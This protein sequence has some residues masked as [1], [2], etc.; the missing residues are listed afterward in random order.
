M[1]EGLAGVHAM[2]RGRVTRCFFCAEMNSKTFC[3]CCESL[4]SLEPAIPWLPGQ[5]SWW[6]AA[7][8]GSSAGFGRG[9]DEESPQIPA[10][11][12]FY[13]TSSR[14]E[15]GTQ[16]SPTEE[17]NASGL[18]DNTLPTAQRH[19]MKLSDSNEAPVTLHTSCTAVGSS[20]V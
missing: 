4:C 11:L 15:P 8:S 18:R 7:C 2:L 10:S 1:D 12:L 16:N 13:A 20:L 14:G 9:L 3:S 5:A 17:T 19:Q 6:S